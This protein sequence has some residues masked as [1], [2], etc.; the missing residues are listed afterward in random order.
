MAKKAADKAAKA[1]KDAEHRLSDADLSALAATFHTSP[2]DHEAG[3]DTASTMTCHNAERETATAQIGPKGGELK[4][5]H[6]SLRVPAG[7]LTSPVVITGTAIRGAHGPLLT[8]APHGL[9]F[10][11]AVEIIADYH[12]CSAPASAPLNMFY[13]APGHAVL[14]V[15]PSAE[16]G[17][18]QEI[19]ALTDHFSGYLVSWNRH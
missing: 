1:A 15:M 10:Q 7:A 4:I 13:V 11:K 8:F 14:Q 5:G 6:S 12:G 19:R 16:H 17:S 2:A 18:K 9:Q 3:V